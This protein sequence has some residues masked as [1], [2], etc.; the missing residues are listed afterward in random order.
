MTQNVRIGEVYVPVT[1]QKIGSFEGLYEHQVRTIESKGNVVILDAPTG[2]GKTLAALARVMSRKTPAVFIYPVNSLV[3]D[4]VGRIGELLSQLGYSSNIIGEEWAPSSVDSAEVGNAVDIIHATGETLEK[5]ADEGA[6]GSVLERILTATDMHGR[7]RIVL[8]N[9][10]VLYLVNSGMYHRHGL[11]SDQLFKFR[12]IVVDEFHLYSGPTLARLLFMLNEMRGNASPPIDL[13]FLSATHGD[14]IDLLRST[15]PQLDLVRAATHVEEGT[16]MRKIRFR[17]SGEIRSQSTVL[18]DEESARQIATEIVKLYGS[19]YEWDNNRP[20]VKV[21]G[22]FSSVTFAVLLARTVKDILNERGID[23]DSVVKQIHGLVPRSARVG[24]KS[25]SEAILIGTSAIEVGVDFDVPFLV[26]EAH[27]LA[28]FLQRFGRGGRHGPCKFLL[29]VPPAMV[30]RLGTSEELSFPAL[31]QEAEEAFREL[32]SY[33]G[34]LCSQ[35]VRIILL[36][37]ARAGSKTY[38]YFTSR[39]DI[40]IKAARQ[41]FKSLINANQNVCVSDQR[42]VDNVGSLDDEDLDADLTKFPVEVMAKHSF[43]RGAMNSILVRYPGHL[44]GLR[45]SY[46]FAELDIFDVFR[47]SGDL[48]LASAYWSDI[49]R[50]LRRRYNKESTI[51]IV[52][53][54]AKQPLP[55]AWIDRNA[56]ARYRTSVFMRRQTTLRT[57]NPQIMDV[58]NDILEKRNLVFFSRGMNRAA[59]YRIPRI[60]A[61]EENGALVIGDWALV[62]EYL[63]QK[64]KEEDKPS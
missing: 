11:I 4:Q 32:P 2:S 51:F 35:Q 58:I 5:L 21:L 25:L 39:E 12:A 28:S 17:T 53:G 15:Y 38:D 3:K 19:E 24:I 56:S 6:K 30:L 9:P 55:K 16:G 45:E 54:F 49:P 27:D 14:L 37:M 57:T 44:L 40:D 52:S 1:D 20:N 29:Y 60:Y 50:P 34:F 43:A 41:Y 42:L 23:A 36:A 59:D 46:L 26:M 10:D 61:E 63:H 18:A 64:Q 22:I 48:D 7:M 62:A 13:V 47:L 33:S 8:T 31:V